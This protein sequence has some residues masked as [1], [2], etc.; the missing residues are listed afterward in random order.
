MSGKGYG[1]V[2]GRI[3]GLEKLPGL[4]VKTGLVSNQREEP[5]VS[6]RLL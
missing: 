2:R 6:L 5:L 3:L 4:S 1:G